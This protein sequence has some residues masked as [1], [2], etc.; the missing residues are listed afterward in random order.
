[1]RSPALKARTSSEL[2]GVN[3]FSQIIRCRADGFLIVVIAEEMNARY[4]KV[5][6]YKGWQLFDVIP[7][8]W[9]VDKTAGSPLHG[10]VFISDG[11]SI[12]NGG[13]NALLRI[14]SPQRRL[15]LEHA[16]DVSKPDIEEQKVEK[17]P[18]QI[19]PDGYARTVNELA[20]QKFKQQLLSDILVDL[21]ICEIEGW[22]KQEYIAEIKALICSIGN[23]VCVDVV[24]SKMEP[25]TIDT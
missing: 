4:A 20:R 17:K 16:I 15:M 7:D 2:L 14:I 22:C 10:Y 5:N 1:M 21:T 18:V 12:I 24:S 19:Y 13:R 8:G 11:K 23:Q 25:A 3:T 9:K 6:A